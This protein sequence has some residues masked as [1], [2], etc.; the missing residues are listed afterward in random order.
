MVAFFGLRKDCAAQRV[1]GFGVGVAG[2]EARESAER[3]VA[4]QSAINAS[5]S[6]IRG[7]NWRGVGGMCS[8]FR[9]GA[10]LHCM[11]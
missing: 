10:V 6:T 2:W 5:S 8:P 3:C 1:A 4:M 11:V 9:A 7:T